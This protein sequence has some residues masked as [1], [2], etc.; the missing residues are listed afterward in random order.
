MPRV[1]AVAVTDVRQAVSPPLA[2]DTSPPLAASVA[3]PHRLR[4]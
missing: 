2:A 3:A 1:F 4:R